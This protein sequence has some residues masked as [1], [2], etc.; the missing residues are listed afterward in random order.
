MAENEK[1]KEFFLE[2]EVRLYGDS[3]ELDLKNLNEGNSYKKGEKIGKYVINKSKK[4][5]PIIMKREKALIVTKINEKLNEKQVNGKSTLTEA[6]LKTLPLFLF[7]YCPHSEVYESI[8]CKC[9]QTGVKKSQKMVGREG[10]KGGIQGM[11]VESIYDERIREKM[12]EMLNKR[13]KLL[14]ILDIDN[15]I[16][17][18]QPMSFETRKTQEKEKK[19]EKPNKIKE[20]IKSILNGEEENDAETGKEDEQSKNEKEASQE[21]EKEADSMC[22]SG[23]PHQIEEESN[24]KETEISQIGKEVRR[25][26]QSEKLLTHNEAIEEAKMDDGE[27]KKPKGPK[28]SIKEEPSG[29]SGKKLE[30]NRNSSTDASHNGNEPSRNLENNVKEALINTHNTRDF[31]ILSIG[32]TVYKRPHL[33]YFLR[34]VSE[35]FEIYMYTMGTRRYA[36]EVLWNIDPKE[37]WIKA[38]RI[39][40]REDTVDNRKTIEDIVGRDYFSTVLILDD[41]RDVWESILKATD[42][43]R[44]SNLIEVPK[45]ENVSSPEAPND[46]YLFFVASFL[47]RIHEMFFTLWNHPSEKVKKLADVRL[48]NRKSNEWALN[49]VSLGI[50][51]FYPSSADAENEEIPKRVR[52]SGG[53]VVARIDSME[54]VG[55]D[56]THLMIDPEVSQKS[57]KIKKAVK[58]GKPV[59]TK[60]WVYF[61]IYFLKEAIGSWE[62]FDALQPVQ[63]YDWRTLQDK[64]KE[65]YT[66][67]KLDESHKKKAQE[68]LKELIEKKAGEEKEA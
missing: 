58:M 23:K 44:T 9:G 66:E 3:I 50:T 12:E 64:L 8:C 36:Q 10:A 5:F 16:L 35:F 4:E 46:H 30:E 38:S 14:L 41:R 1:E 27:T 40:S 55:K 11:Y 17:E 33:S 32:N 31:F 57:L 29:Q 47:L 49:G 43:G 2:P 54:E 20:I 63:S 22:A 56:L 45:F 19:N 53:R 18:C 15:T 52:G 34:R 42:K 25:N 67:E 37:E 21:K 61:S 7:K 6:E 39:I 24:Q 28:E 68:I 48:L 65:T 62:I 60:D 59:V 51:C 26:E 13:K